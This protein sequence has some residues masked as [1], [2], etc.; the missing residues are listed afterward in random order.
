MNNKLRHNVD[1]V[2]IDSDDGEKTG[3]GILKGKFAG[4]LYHYGKAKL[5][6]E[7]AFARMTFDYTVVTTPKIPVDELMRDQEF[8]Y[9]LGE[10]LT[11]ILLNYKVKN[12]ETGN[13]D[14]EEFD[15]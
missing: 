13:Y 4:V 6:E 5:T 7:E 9:M 11:D 3:V 8:Q 10:I 1:Y 12:E 2:L 15:I 14:S